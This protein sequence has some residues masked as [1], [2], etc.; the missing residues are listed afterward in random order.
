MKIAF[1][2]G[3]TIADLTDN[4]PQKGHLIPDQEWIPVHDGIDVVIDDVAAGRM[5]S[6]AA[7]MKIRSIIGAS[8]RFVWQCRECGRLFVNDRQHQT[9]TFAPTSECREI[10]KSRDQ[11]CAE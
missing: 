2:C 11:R 3:A 6:S 7:Y 8:A 9:H 5:P 4:L 10:L 1:Q